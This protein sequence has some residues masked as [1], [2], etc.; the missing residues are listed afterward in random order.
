MRTWQKVEEQ[1]SENKQLTIVIDD[2]L[3][4]DLVNELRIFV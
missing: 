3:I 1:K 2:H 4:G